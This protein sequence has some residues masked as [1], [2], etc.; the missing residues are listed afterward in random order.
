MSKEKTAQVSFVQE[1]FQPG[2]YKRNQ[3]RIA[4]QVTFAALAIIVSLGCFRLS[5][6]W[7]D[8]APAVRFGI[9]GALLV[10]GLWTCYRIVN[11][12]RFADFLISVEGEMAKVSWPSRSELIRSSIVVIVTVIFLAAVLF[13]YDLIWNELLKALGIIS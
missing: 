2:L 9:P 3:G 7:I 1:L 11:I 5:Q 13:A 6:F 12:S 10:V 4:R 8:A